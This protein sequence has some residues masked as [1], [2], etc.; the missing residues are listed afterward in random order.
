[1][2]HCSAMG[3]TEKVLTSFGEQLSDHLLVERPNKSINAQGYGRLFLG[4]WSA[5]CI[6]PQRC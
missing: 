6:L 5:L 2:G 4:G 3:V 1:M